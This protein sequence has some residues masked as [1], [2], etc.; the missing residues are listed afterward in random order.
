MLSKFVGKFRRFFAFNELL[1]QLIIRDV[2]L[3]YR[4]SLFRVSVEYFEPLNVNDGSC[5]YFL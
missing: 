3:K 1:K 4:R 2:K 5:C